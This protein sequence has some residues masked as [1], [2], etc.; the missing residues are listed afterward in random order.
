VHDKNAAFAF[1]F[2]R[3]ASDNELISV[4]CSNIAVGLVGSGM[5]ISGDSVN[6][7]DGDDKAS[8]NLDRES[9]AASLAGDDA[10]GVANAVTS[11]TRTPAAKNAAAKQSNSD[12]V[13]VD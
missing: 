6:F 8:I 13:D 4:V 10:T 11:V 12:D 3:S 2:V 1:A 5:T 9:S 7:P